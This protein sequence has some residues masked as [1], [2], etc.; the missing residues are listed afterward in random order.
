MDDDDS[1]ATAASPAADLTPLLERSAELAAVQDALREA[2][3][4]GRGRL[5]VVEGAAGIGKTRLLRAAGGLATDRGWDV[6]RAAGSQ[7]ERA[8]PFGVALQLFES[9]LKRLLPAEREHLLSGAAAAAGGLFAGT[10]APG[11]PPGVRA[12]SVVHGL[13]WLTF[14]LS[15][16]AALALVVD[17]AQW[18]DRESLEFLL[19]LGRRLEDLPALMALSWRTGEPDSPQEL[20]AQLCASAGGRVLRPAPLSTA[21]VRGLVQ[22]RFAEAPQE[23]CRA[24]A[25]ACAGNPFLLHE[26]LHALKA[27]NVE[28]RAL[29]AAQVGRLAP[30]TIRRSVMLRLARLPDACARLAQAIAVLGPDATLRRAATLANLTPELASHTADTL[31]A[32][33]IIDLSEQPRFAHPLLASAVY[34]DIPTAARADAHLR[35][36]HDLGDEG[37]APERLA[38]HLLVA[39][40]SGDAWVVQTLLSAARHALADG[41]PAAAVQ[42]L[43]RALAEPPPIALRRTLLVELA[44]AEAVSGDPE[45][46]SQRLSEALTLTEEPRDRASILL[47][48]GHALYLHGELHA[49]RAAFDEGLAEVPGQDRELEAELEAGWV[50]IAR[51]DPSMRAEAITRL[52][53]ILERRELGATHGE[54]VLLAQ[55]AEQLVFA[56]EQ[57][58]RAIDLATRAIADGTLITEETSDGM[59][60]VVAYAALAWSDEVKL[61]A[62]GIEAALEDARRRGSIT[63][64]AQASYCRSVLLYRAG[65]LTGAAADLDAAIEGI[66]H[67]WRQ[68]LPAVRAQHA[69]VL[70]ELGN[71]DA[72][73]AT[74]AEVDEHE[75][76]Q[77][78]MYALLLDARAHL[79]L[80]RGY[81]NDALRDA[82]GASRLAEAALVANPAWFPWRSR[83]AL[84]ASRLGDLDRARELVN[85][86]LRLARRFGAP[87]PIGVALRAAGLIEPGGAGIEPLREAIDVLKESPAQLE[88]AHALVDLGSALRRQRHRADARQPLREGLD[89]AQRFGARLIA[90]QA[91]TE[92]L[93]TGARPR[94]HLLSGVDSLTPSERRVAEL[95]AEGLSNR[96]IAQALFISLRT[97]EAHLAH[98]YRKLNVASRHELNQAFAEHPV[99]PL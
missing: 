46:A 27:D 28:V 21:A 84:A 45:S 94:R 97:V 12:L 61:V 15:E 8:L 10:G 75:W 52:N 77:T 86:E 58:E 64:F 23:F 76:G 14:N 68:F 43:R 57:R 48:L 26:L 40:E 63:G 20:L 95:A 6:L 13:Y 22:L 66:Q 49:A 60:W 24:C 79:H 70:S 36:A 89:M 33:D 29:N 65:Q 62:E 7:L 56:G 80:L 54:R 39:R 2:A 88:Y 59:N 41:A 38:V 87:R 32:T 53:R 91:R 99:A 47:E 11:G 16:R 17:D 31:A 96:Q 30:P 78:L 18:A 35:A 1:T 51:L 50:S 82:L 3:S 44:G 9:R 93:A 25:H 92:L 67:G 98:A 37:L 90:E 42:Y 5:L 34:A 55:A 19:Y 83:A 69:W 4:S 81:P 74:L 71:I 72:A 73:A 85:D